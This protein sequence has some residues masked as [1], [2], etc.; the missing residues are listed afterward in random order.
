[1]AASTPVSMPTEETLFPVP[2]SL[3]EPQREIPAPE[4]VKIN[5]LIPDYSD[6]PLVGFSRLE[7]HQVIP[8]YASKLR[9]CV[10]LHV[11][12]N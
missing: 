2:P 4:P 5:D 11:R 3:K 6:I 1:M 12:Q 9:I 10:S 7:L 8:G